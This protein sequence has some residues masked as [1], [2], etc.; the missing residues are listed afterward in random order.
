VWDWAVWGA[1][2]VAI[3]SGI[4]ALV[5][6]VRRVL[7]AFRSFKT[8]YSGGVA[9]LSSLAAKAEDTAAKAERAGDTCE[10]REAVARLRG[11]IAQLTI[12]RAALADA[13][14]QLWW[15]RALL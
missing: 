5:L 4:A 15:V 12:L 2:V 9:G 11:A 10:L 13:D 14:R 6:L 1:L 7:E 8:A 3:C